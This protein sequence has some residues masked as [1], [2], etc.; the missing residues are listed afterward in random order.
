MSRLERWY[1]GDLPRPSA[2]PELPPVGAERLIAAWLDGLSEDTVA[3]YRADLK[4]FARFLGVAG[5]EAAAKQL[6]GCSNVQAN[7]LALEFRNDM[8]K[9][10]LA[11]ASV[12]RRLAA[13]KS[14]TKVARQIGLITWAL[15]VKSLPAEAYRDTRGPG[16]EGFRKLLEPLELRSDAQAARDRAIL[17]L[18]FERGLRSKEVRGLDLSDVDFQRGTLMVLGKRRLQ[19]ESLSVAPGTIEALRTWL[20]WR[21][22]WAGPLFVALPKGLPPSAPITF[23]KAPSRLSRQSIYVAVRRIGDDVGI[24]ARPHGLRHAAITEALDRGVDV[25]AVQRFSRHKDLRTL[26][27]YDDN[28]TDLAGQVACLVADPTQRTLSRRADGRTQLGEANPRSKITADQVREIR[29]RAVNETQSSL[30]REFGIRQQQVHKIVKGT[31]WK[32]V[33]GA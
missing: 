13:L 5:D 4:V 23:A 8:K 10:G 3:N 28:R 15:E 30:A 31:S 22:E 6:L 2:A 20:R 17:K 14:F 24:R 9:R 11:P 25:R 32:H 33:G 21:G 16:A 1:E 7:L 12:N 26:M 19:K 18:L 29:R 27:I